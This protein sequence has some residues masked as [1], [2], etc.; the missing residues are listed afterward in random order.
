MP[1]QKPP[2]NGPEIDDDDNEGEDVPP[3]FNHG[4]DDGFFDDRIAPADDK[5]EKIPLPEI[6]TTNG[7]SHPPR[8][9]SIPS[10]FPHGP[11]EY[12]GPGIVGNVSFVLSSFNFKILFKTIPEDT[13][14]VIPDINVYQHK[15]T[16]AQGMMDLALLSANAN[17]LRYVLESYERHPYYYFSV[18]FILASLIL[19]VLVG[20]GLVFN[21]RY[22]IK[23]QD[24]I[25]KADRINNL[26]TVAILLI[27]IIN[28]F[29]SAFGVAEKK[30]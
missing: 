11:P 1:R 14:R 29:I 18:T 4:I 17:Q 27:T 16:L 9:G 12:G 6:P 15:K 26:I 22:N 21:S 13:T 28:V 2:Q 23:H 24:D 7:D 5:T 10:H 8:R 20:V 30:A 3:T 25:C 19:Q